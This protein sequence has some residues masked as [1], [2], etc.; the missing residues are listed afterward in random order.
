MESSAPWRWRGYFGVEREVVLF[1]TSDLDPFSISI[2]HGQKVV[3]T[4]QRD[5]NFPSP[6]A[7]CTWLRGIALGWLDP[8]LKPQHLRAEWEHSLSEIWTGCAPHKRRQKKLRGRIIRFLSLMVHVVASAQ[9][10]A[11]GRDSLHLVEVGNGYSLPCGF[12]NL[13]IRITWGSS[14]TIQL[15]APMG[16]LE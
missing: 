14:K 16:L 2:S 11:N 10:E 5:K 3:M 8:T 15:P 9:W 1:V 13:C 12:E 6:W 4:Q 7:F